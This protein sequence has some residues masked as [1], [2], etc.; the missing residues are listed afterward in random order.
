MKLKKKKVKCST[1]K[2]TSD[3]HFRS[4]CKREERYRVGKGEENKKQP[5]AEAPKEICSKNKTNNE[6][7]GEGEGEGEG[8]DKEKHNRNIPSLKER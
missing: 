4:T 3:L 7:N 5:R 6:E 2:G 1:L 8:E